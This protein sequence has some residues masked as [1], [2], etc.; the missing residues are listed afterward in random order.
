M[1][2]TRTLVLPSG[3][4]KHCTIVGNRADR[5]DFTGFGIVDGGV[6]LRR[7]E[8][9]LVAPQ[10]RFQSIDGRFAAD[11][12]WHHHERE[13]HDVADWNHGE[14]CLL[15][16]IF[17]AHSC[18]FLSLHPLSRLFERQLGFLVHHHFLRDG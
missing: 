12:E 10:C 11:D 1:P 3:S 6:V 5:E 14:P 16:F 17:G 9:A 2:S 18:D 13:D 8:D 4:F 15:V 7:E